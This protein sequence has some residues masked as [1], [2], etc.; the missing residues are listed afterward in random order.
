MDTRYLPNVERE[1]SATDECCV[2][3]QQAHLKRATEESCNPEAGAI[4]LQL[5]IML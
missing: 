4:Y 1:E 3:M 2:K 5:F